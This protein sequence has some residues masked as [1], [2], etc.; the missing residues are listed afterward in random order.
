M[1]VSVKAVKRQWRSEEYIFLIEVKKMY[2][3]YS[4]LDH[5]GKV[6]LYSYFLMH[7]IWRMFHND[8]IIIH[9]KIAVIPLKNSSTHQFLR[10]SRINNLLIILF[11]FSHDSGYATGLRKR[12]IIISTSCNNY[13]N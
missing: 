7:Q 12:I 13:A 5:I 11:F 6:F 3:I 10:L 1:L 8:V 2:Y 4:V 9:I